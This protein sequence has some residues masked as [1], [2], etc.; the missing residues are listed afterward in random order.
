MM[1]NIKHIRFLCMILACAL[2]TTGCKT[3]RTVS[4]PRDMELPQDFVIK[5]TSNADSIV[6]QSTVFVD[7]FLVQLIDIA[8]RDN[9]DVLSAI[10]RIEVAR[11]SFRIRKGALLPSVEGA[12]IASGQKYGDYTMEGVGNFDTNLSGNITDDQKVPQPVVPNYFLGLRSSWEIDLWGK[13]NSQK[14]AAYLRLLGTQQ[15]RKLVITTLVAEVSF[16]YYELLA[17]DEELKIL[18]KNMKLQDSAV[19]MAE[20]QKEAGRA[21]ALGIQQFRAQLLRTQ[22]LL[23]QS[24]QDIARVENELNQLLGRFPQLIKRSKSFLHQTLPGQM[25]VSL[26]KEILNRR[27][28][29]LQAETELK[30]TK[31]D[32]AAAKAALL[33]ALTLSPFL[34]YSAFK[35]SL[36]F[37]PGSMIYGIVGGVTAPLLNR[38]SLKG[39]YKRSEAEKM[40]AYYNYNK[41]VLNAFHEVQTTLSNMYSL[42][43]MYELNQQ[44]TQVLAEAVAT[45]NEL[46]KA[47]YA[48][49]LDVITAQRNALEAEINQVE[50]KKN[51]L[52]SI[53]TL[54]RTSGGGWR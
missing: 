22:S 1:S 38:S 35:G 20:I 16:R 23:V 36:L 29:V 13:L 53:I 32:V 31:A 17:L 47:G 37:N 4:M 43:K 40:E 52:M 54:Y 6:S 27:P 26:P 14:Q 12:A 11:S 10:Q 49:Y 34:G 28:D 19:Y 9:P 39:N 51:L 24:E 25:A 7:S 2:H 5:R 30:A 44:E 41:T 50:T 8:V 45:S 21:T 42:N 48:T 15:A 33:P 46:F 18:L 3:A